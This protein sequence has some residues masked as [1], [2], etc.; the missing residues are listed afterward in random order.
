METGGPD[1]RGRP[2][3]LEEV[4]EI[5]L[6]TGGGLGC[7]FSLGS[8]LGLPSPFFSRLADAAW[9]CA[10]GARPESEKRGPLGRLPVESSFPGSCLYSCTREL[11]PQCVHRQ[12]FD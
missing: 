2:R 9:S 3:Q 10:R 6:G 1:S 7:L 11:H 4:R 8:V 12:K 5:L